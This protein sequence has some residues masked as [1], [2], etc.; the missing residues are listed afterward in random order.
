[1]KK[2]TKYL[3]RVILIALVLGGILF[4]FKSIKVNKIICEN[5][6]GICRTSIKN[7]IANIKDK[8][9]FEIYPK[10]NNLFKKDPAVLQYRIDFHLPLN[11]KVNAVERK[12]IAAFVLSNKTF[13][14]VDKDGVTTE[15]VSSTALPQI[16]SINLST[17]QVVYI[18]NLVSELYTLYG[19]KSANVTEDGLV[20]DKLGGKKVYFPLDGD[21]DVL[22]G[23]LSLILSRLPRLQEDSTIAEQ[24]TI[25]II[26]LRFKNPVLKENE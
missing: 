10:L 16:S 22:L 19:V 17:T 14:L 15:K 18:A 3:L 23:S 21:K 24:G 5:Q 1:M 9:I 13:A 25:G 8:N 20:I 12:P 7:Q 11:I 4:V 2:I 6:F 26:D